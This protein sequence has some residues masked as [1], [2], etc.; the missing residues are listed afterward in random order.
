MLFADEIFPANDRSVQVPYFPA[1]YQIDVQGDGKRD[2]IVA[3]NEAFGGNDNA[4]V[5]YY[6]NQ[7]S[8]LN[9]EFVLQDT[10]WLQRT[11][12]DLGTGAAPT[13]ID[14]NADGKPDLLIGNRFRWIREGLSN[15]SLTLLKNVGTAD[16]LAFELV[17]RDYLFLASTP[18]VSGLDYLHP[19]AVDLDGDGDHDLLLG[20]VDAQGRG[21]IWFFENTAAPG[22]EARMTLR[23]S[24]YLGL[25]AQGITGPPILRAPAPA[26]YD[27]DGDGD[28]DLVIGHN[29]G[30][31]WAFENRG[32]S[33]VPDF[34]FLTYEWG[35]IDVKEILVDNFVGA[36]HPA[37]ADLDGDGQPELLV[38]NLDGRVWVYANPSLDTG[39]VFQ[40]LGTL[41]G[42]DLGGFIRPAL[43]NLGTLD[44]AQWVYA[45]GCGRGGLML[46]AGPAAIVAD[47]T[48]SIAPGTLRP[49]QKAVAFE[50]WPNPARMIDPVRISTS[51]AG[52]LRI[53]N[54]MG[55]AAM[56]ISIQAGQIYTLDLGSLSAGVYTL[57]LETDSG[58]LLHRRV[59]LQ[60]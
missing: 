32:D 13:W 27:L 34:Q 28:L 36:A 33:Q 29:N 8:D 15:T 53:L 14:Y 11:M 26:T 42:L 22:Q 41:M 21:A 23:S 16:S 5:W 7:G 38:G 58:Q 45:L 51:E 50:V 47:T 48:D 39:A 55:Q 2:L 52:Q 46:L 17:T 57:L 12:L 19:H 6:A 10:A 20:V 9:P 1:G 35:G 24:D 30:Q 49:D 25:R 54:M 56:Q 37:L 31:L 43:F 4:A 60:P 18:G 59:V 3:P 44:S 40:P